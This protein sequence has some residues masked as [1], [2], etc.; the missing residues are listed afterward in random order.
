MLPVIPVPDRL[1]ALVVEMRA[2]W[3]RQPGVWVERERWLGAASAYA[4]LLEEM[5][6]ELDR[7]SGRAFVLG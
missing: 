1:A 7:V 3:P 6:G 4:D 2:G 5:P